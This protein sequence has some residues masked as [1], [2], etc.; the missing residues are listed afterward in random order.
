MG[1]LFE[2]SFE[3]KSFFYL[4]ILS[5]DFSRIWDGWTSIIFSRM[6]DFLKEFFQKDVLF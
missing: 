3:L 2:A 4:T 6:F 5:R 1:I